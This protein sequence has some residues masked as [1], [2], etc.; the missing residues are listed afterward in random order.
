M[1]L[2]KKKIKKHPEKQKKI[3]TQQQ[4]KTPREVNTVLKRPSYKT[5]QGGREAV[6]SALILSC[7]LSGLK[8]LI[9][10]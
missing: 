6:F 2:I 9:S 10:I 4:K 8:C 5:G 1:L 3:P 7:I